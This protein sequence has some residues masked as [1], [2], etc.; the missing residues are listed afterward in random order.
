MASELVRPAVVSF[1]DRMLRQKGGT[2]RVEEVTVPEDAKVDGQTLG[3][4]RV[5]DIAGAMLLAVR[6]PG[7]SEFEFKPSPD[8]LLLPGMTLVVMADV[9]GHGRLARQF[10]RA[11]GTFFRAEVS[12]TD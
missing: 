10:Q 6:P 3:S 4:L 7:A 5:N 11:T 9:E 12:E 2:L 8:T 1:L